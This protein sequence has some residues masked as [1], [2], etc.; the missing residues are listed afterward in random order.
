MTD[1][2]TLLWNFLNIILCFLPVNYN[3]TNSNIIQSSF[4]LH[5]SYYYCWSGARQERRAG[6]SESKMSLNWAIEGILDHFVWQLTSTKNFSWGTKAQWL[7]NL[8]NIVLKSFCNKYVVFTYDY[9]LDSFSNSKKKSIKEISNMW[10]SWQHGLLR[11]RG[12][13]HL[14][15][16]MYFSEKKGIGIDVYQTDDVSDHL[17][18]RISYHFIFHQLARYTA[19]ACLWACVNSPSLSDH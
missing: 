5:T 16:Q 14:V 6:D 19:K 18:K 1:S 9:N 2:E 13:Y 11:S 12:S 4:G 15:L 17:L 7:H 8:V 3:K 10:H